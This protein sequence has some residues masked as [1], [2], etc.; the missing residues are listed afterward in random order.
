MARYLL[1]NDDELIAPESGDDIAFARGSLKSLSNFDKKRIS[2]K[3]AK[4]IVDGLEAV[5]I[6]EQE[7]E[8]SIV[9]LRHLNRSLQ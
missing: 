8:F 6:D 9:A 7:S 4:R 5:K 3:M 2:M 1:K